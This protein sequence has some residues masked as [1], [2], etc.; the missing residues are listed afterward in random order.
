MLL[1]YGLGTSSSVS[2][3]LSHLPG[4]KEHPPCLPWKVA[5]LPRNLRCCSFSGIWRKKLFSYSPPET[6]KPAGPQGL[7]FLSSVYVWGPVVSSGGD[8]S[9]IIPVH[10]IFN[11]L[12]KGLFQS[13]VWN[14]SSALAFLLSLFRELG[15]TIPFMKCKNGLQ[16]YTCAQCKIGSIEL[17]Y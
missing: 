3:L 11:S 15:M 6:T 5:P 13:G 16:R 8:H 2:A 12:L 14:L 1:E 17:K 10:I 7:P 9:P 4:N